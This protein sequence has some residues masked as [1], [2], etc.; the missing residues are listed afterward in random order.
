MSFDVQ[1]IPT[2]FSD[3]GKKKHKDR[4]KLL[5]PTEVKGQLGICSFVEAVSTLHF[6][7]ASGSRGYGLQRWRNLGYKHT[8]RM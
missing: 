1:V 3:N 7:P 8:S 2:A 6:L 5:P 4:K